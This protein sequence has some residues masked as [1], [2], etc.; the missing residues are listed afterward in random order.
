MSNSQSAPLGF[1]T[2]EALVRQ[3]LAEA[4]GGARGVVETAVPTL[5]FTIWF[6][7]TGQLRNGLVIATAVTVVLLVVRVVQRSSTQF[8]INALVGIGIAALFASRSGEARDVFL[9][10]ILYNGAYAVVLTLTILIGWPLVG[11]LVG[12]M[13]G[14]LTSWRQDRGLRVLC[15]RLTWLLVLPCV[16]RV[17]IQYPLWASDRIGLLATSKIALG[18]PLQIAS[19]L[20]MAWVLSRNTIPLETN[21][22][23]S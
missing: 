22:V 5:V 16:V 3:R 18:W 4:F 2:V 14:D 21:D 17:L 10:G 15:S 12:G 13:V 9:P 7:T 6:L 8:V 11:F 19:L 1:E 23:E 20:A